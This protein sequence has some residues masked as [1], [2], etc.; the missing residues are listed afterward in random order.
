MAE[1]YRQSAHS[2]VKAQAWGF[3]N[4][5][6]LVWDHTSSYHQVVCI[7][8][9]LQH[10]YRPREQPK[11]PDDHQIYVNLP[12][13]ILHCGNLRMVLGEN[14]ALIQFDFSKD[15][16]I[17]LNLLRKIQFFSYSLPFFFFFTTNFGFKKHTQNTSFNLK[18]FCFMFAKH[19]STVVISSLDGL[20]ENTLPPASSVQLLVKGGSDADV[21]CKCL[22]IKML[23]LLINGE[24]LWACT[25]ELI[26]LSVLH[27]ATLD[28]H[29]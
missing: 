27:S 28:L 18:N 25:Q 11:P 14:Q 8:R 17:L 12:P 10:G 6:I 4:A 22:E 16:N 9:A 13:K 1:S 29:L 3:A 20:K 5:A 2:V 7:S 15:Q 21:L 19:C 23:T 24:S 26:K